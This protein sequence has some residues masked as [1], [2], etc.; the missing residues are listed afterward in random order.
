MTASGRYSAQEL[1][2]LQLLSQRYPTITAAHIEM[3]NLSAI[4]ALP[5]GTDHYIS[6]IHGAY[7]QF[8]HILRHASGAIRRKISQTFGD[9]LSPQQQVELAMLIYYPEKK[10]RQVLGALDDP[11]QWMAA[12]IGHLVRVARTSSQKYTRSKVRKRLSP[13]LAYIL[14][15]LLAESQAD[16]SQKEHYYSSI[17]RSIVAL[18]EGENAIVTL[19]Y[20]IQR[21]V[22]DRLYILG[23]IY[24]R[25][26]A[27]ERVMDRLMAYHYVAIQWGNH[28]VSWMGAASGCDALI[29]NVLRMS[30]RYGNLETLTD[31]YDISLWRLA[32]FAEATYRDDPSAVFQPHA[33]PSIEGFSP[34]LIAR[35]HKAITIIQF[36]LEARIIQRHPEYAMADRLVLDSINVPQG[37]ATLYGAT[38]PLLDTSWPTLD[39]ADRAALTDG[40]AGVVADL[41]QQFQDSARLQEHIRFLYSYGNMFQVQDGNLKFHGCLPVDE[42]GEFVA[43]PLGGDV[44][45]GPALLERYEQ[46]A[47]EAFFSHDPRARQAG[48]DAIWYLWCGPQSPLFGR[49]RMTTFERYF[50]ADKATH[51]EPKGPYYALRDSEAFCRKVLAA[52]GGDVE[53]GHIINGHTPVQVKKGERPLMANGKLIVIDGGMSE[54]YQPV[55]GIAGYTL[56][57]NSHELVLAAHEPFT[58]ADEMILQGIDVTPHAERIETF[59]QRLL[60]E[61]TDTGQML[62]GQLEDLQKLV[63]AY[64]NGVL[65]ENARGD[66]PAGR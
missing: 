33:G 58:T 30:L 59:P 14:E 4:L 56:I 26:P 55:T 60:I 41:R 6:D 47:R 62:R 15:E 2:L 43:F 65:V 48:Q 28:D 39:L 37:T 64:R 18:G 9:E 23:D 40:E 22:V 3:I 54:P 42:Q 38:Y 1:R 5:K 34:E 29:A 46:M 49:E 7:E 51:A 44:L 53:H 32:R 13:Q 21:L 63:D 35:M 57:G 24:D 52:F 8:D 25:G 16:H 31:G 27:A 20:L 45:A 61:A 50:I 11:E 19:A 10:L 17:V 36:K 12:T 66:R